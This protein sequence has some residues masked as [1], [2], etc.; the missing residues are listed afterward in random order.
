MK[1]LSAGLTFVNVMTVCGLL[2]GIPGHGLNKTVAIYSAV[3]GLA[4]ALLAYWGTCDAP[5]QE[6]APD[7]TPSPTTPESKPAR[8]R[9]R[10]DRGLAVVAPASERY[11]SIWL[12]LV[13]SLFSIYIGRGNVLTP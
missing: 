1:W 2:G 9:N 3:A 13:V 5:A 12:L 10:R 8:R 6:E 7:V 4:A 11:P